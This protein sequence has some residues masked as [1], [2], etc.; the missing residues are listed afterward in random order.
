MGRE[1]EFLIPGDIRRATGGYVYDRRIVA[2]LRA[3][4]W[5]VTVHAL[6]ASFPRPSPAALV[7]AEAVLA[8]IPARRLVL[9]DGLALS[10]MPQVARAHAA[11]LALVALVHMP[12]SAD[13]Q[14]DPQR[15][16]QVRQ[17]EIDALRS[18][19][20]VI[21]TGSSS[22]QV[23]LGYGLQSGQISVIEP[24][25]DEVPLARR[26]PDGSVNMLCV[27]TVHPIKG[28]ELLI[29]ALAPLVSLPWQ[30]TC[31]GSVTQS[32]ETA[33]RVRAQLERCGLSDRVVLLG[34][35]QPPVLA[36]YFLQSDLLVLASRF[37]SYCMAIAEG[38]A[39][40]LPAVS[41]RT[42][43]IPDLV[44]DQAGLLVEIGDLPGLRAALAAALSQPGLLARLAEGAAIARQQ[45]PRWSEVGTKFSGS[46]QEL[47]WRKHHAAS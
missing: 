16:Q 25:T 6:D 39:Y 36:Q 27:A 33:A 35:V 18:A 44:G 42:G 9:I 37:E 30:L 17:A 46:L 2:E 41:T 23:L 11:R 24:G 3:R 14:H 13:T 28:H 10:A 47:L 38:L 22:R 12:L 7:H 19:R 15:A 29:D 5:Q 20:H 4:G 1:L 34:E 40:G 45:L 8:G 32:P 21:V 26:P 43:A 31:I